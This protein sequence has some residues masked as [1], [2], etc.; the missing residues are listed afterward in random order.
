MTLYRPLASPA[1]GRDRIQEGLSPS[2]VSSMV[3][4]GPG[5][6][7]TVFLLGI[8]GEG[9]LLRPRRSSRKPDAVILGMYS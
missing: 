7:I 6:L 5:G 3:P 2:V 4:Y 8:E 1:A 9:N